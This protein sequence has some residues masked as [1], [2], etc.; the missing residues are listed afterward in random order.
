MPRAKIVGI[1]AVEFNGRDGTPVKR[2]TIHTSEDLDPKRG[3]GVR[4]EHYF[5]SDAK[6]A[7]L[8]FRPAVGQN[9]NVYFK[10]D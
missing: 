10:P 7:N 8:T 9:V 4:V 5:M 1:E 2:V 6:L 3:Q